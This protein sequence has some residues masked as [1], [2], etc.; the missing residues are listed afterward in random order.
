MVIMQSVSNWTYNK[1]RFIGLCRWLE[2]YENN[3]TIR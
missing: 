2:F 1:R 3:F